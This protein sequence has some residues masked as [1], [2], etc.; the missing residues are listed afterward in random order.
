MRNLVFFLNT[1]STLLLVAATLILVNHYS[2]SQAA[3]LSF[4]TT[5]IPKP[6][7]KPLPT[8]QPLERK[9]EWQWWRRHSQINRSMA[10][11]NVDLVFLGDSLTQGWND[12]PTW[13]TFYG[14]RRA[15]NAGIW[16]DRTQHLLWRIQNGN[17]KGINPK[18]IVLQIGGN[19]LMME[20]PYA[21]AGGVKQNLLEIQAKLPN[22]KILIIGILPAGRQ[23]SHPR[24][25]RGQ[26]VNR[27][28]ARF[29]DGE[30]VFFLDVSGKLLT[31]DGRFTK[32][33]SPD[34]LHLTRTGYAILARSI[35]PTL[36]KMLGQRAVVAGRADLPKR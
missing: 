25:A 22:V 30:Q 7:V 12:N 3:P 29:A 11:G 13:Q 27:I 9:T 31:K 34:A 14:H 28:L 16:S 18:A 5:E 19:N 21:V 36:S 35:E 26:E 15:V 10:R 33:V 4:N 23:P 17:L 1:C 32:V 6:V 8:I 2:R 24:R 20:S